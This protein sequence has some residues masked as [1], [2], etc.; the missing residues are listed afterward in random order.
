MKTLIL[1]LVLLLVAV[2]CA[3]E[4]EHSGSITITFPCDTCS[5]PNDT[6]ITVTP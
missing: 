3:T 5:A 1:G 2:A 4:P 6:T